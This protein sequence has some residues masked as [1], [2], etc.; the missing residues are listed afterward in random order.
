MKDV[1]EKCS[2]KKTCR[3]PCRPIELYLAEN[4]LS[5]YEK[6]FKRKN[7]E[8]VSIIYARSRE[9]PETGLMQK[10]TGEPARKSLEVFSTEND[11]PFA[12]FNPH[13]KQTGIFIDRFFNKASYDDLAVKYNVTPHAAIKIY[14]AA[15][16]RLFEVLEAMDG[17]RD[18]RN[19][20]YWK[21]RVED[22][23]GSLPKGQ[24]WFLLN[25]LFGLRPSEIAE[26]E[27]LDK[28]SSSVRQL[29]IRVSDQLK[30]GEISLIEV[31]PEETQAAKARLDAH[32]AKRR[33][34]HARKIQSH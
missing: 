1:C 19:L 7:G 27:G 31:T 15:S 14:Y 12:G 3:S 25:K 21:K 34:R 28:K 24:K 18:M 33:E 30:A 17:K 9:I 20:D 5:V 23:S 16:R 4:N 26:M 32:N 6:T 2:H 8:T 10:F 13:L 29:I 11:S 22:R